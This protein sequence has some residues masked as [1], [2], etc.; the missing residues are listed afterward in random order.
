MDAGGRARLLLYL[1]NIL[2]LKMTTPLSTTGNTLTNKQDFN[3]LKNGRLNLC[4]TVS[5]LQSSIVK[6]NPNIQEAHEIRTWCDNKGFEIDVEDLSTK[7]DRE[8][9]TPFK[10]IGQITSEQLGSNDKP[11]YIT[12]KAICLMIK[13][14]SVVYMSCPAEN[15]SKKVIDN[16]DGTFRCEKCNASHGNFKW[17]YMANA[18]ISDSTGS[19]WITLFRN[20]AEV[21]FGIT[22]EE[23]GQMKSNNDEEAINAVVTKAQNNE[24]MFKL[25]IKIDNYNDEQRLRVTCVNISDV[26][27]VNN[28]KQLLVDINQLAAS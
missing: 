23:F 3:Y 16:G 22:P 25:R 2:G 18:E 9:M 14:D 24:K 5:C 28:V 13:K 27:Y 4:R 17:S 12:C 20:E 1:D 21:L 6:I 15:C 10:T 11:D 19:Q 26:E 8:R 7:T